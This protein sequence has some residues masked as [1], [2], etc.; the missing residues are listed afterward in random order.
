MQG[1]NG[2]FGSREVLISELRSA[3]EPLRE[4]CAAEVSERVDAVVNEAVQAWEETRSEL[5]ALCTKYQH[6]I[7]LWQQYR[8]SSAAVKAWVDTQM[9][10]VANLPPE[11][12][13]KQ[14]KVRRISYFIFQRSSGASGLFETCLGWG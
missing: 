9:G 6:A 11:E 2:D 3:A 8:D 7:R 14:V 5:G 13:L 4:S 10:S 1:L 12:A